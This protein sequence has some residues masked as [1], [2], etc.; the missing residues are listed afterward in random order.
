MAFYSILSSRALRSC[1]SSIALGAV[2]LSSGCDM[3]TNYT[4]IDR[5][6]DMERQ[7]FRDGLSPRDIDFETFADDAGGIPSLESYIAPIS[8]NLRPMPLV[9]LAVNQTVPLKNVLYELAEQ[10]D[11][12][13][14]LDP[15]IT[16]SIIFT[17]RNRPFDMVIERISEIA[18]LRYSFDDD[19]LRVQLD[20]PYTETYQLNYLAVVR[21]ATS[22]VSNSV[23]VVTGDGADAGSSFSITSEAESDFWQDLDENL[24]QILQSNVGN[25]SLRTDTDP[26]LTVVSA[27]PAAPVVAVQPVD[28]S[29]LGEGSPVPTPGQDQTAPPVVQP[30]TVTL[31]VGALPTSTA[32]SGSNDPNEVSFEPAFSLNKQAGLISVYANERIHNEVDKYLEKLEATM[33]AQVLVE[34]KVL[35]VTLSDEYSTGINWND[36]SLFS[37][38]ISTGFSAIVGGGGRAA[39]TPTDAANNFFVN[40]TSGDISAVVEAISRFGTVKALA[41]PRLTV[42]N[43]Q[44][45]A[46]NVAQNTVYFDV[47]VETSI[48]TNGNPLSTFDSEVRTVP[49][50][51]LINVTPTINMENRSITMQ[52]RPTVTRIINRVPD[53]AVEIEAARVGVNVSSDVPELNVQEIDSVLKMNSGEVV[54]LGGL[55][56]DQVNSSQE[57]VPVL[58]EIPILGALFRSQSDEITKTE[59]VIFLKATILDSGRDSIHQ[60]DRELYKTFANDRR[61]FKM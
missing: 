53:P 1:V 54:V 28:G 5:T 43:N 8:D 41:S 45:A 31:Q 38:N 12:D 57:G 10:A 49:E 58:N 14:E 22:S 39:L 20:T 11:Y 51:V 46:L 37:G 29:A 4:K 60:T 2:L 30:P 35:E 17:A 18:G 52:V 16:G 24:D 42:L 27:N 56:Q 36:V 33:M 47:T 15:R 3:A 6:S 34:V 55:L 26:T 40:Y 13:V 19:I 21:T 44:P 9:S 59:L 61:P 23:S 32:S 50:G 7:D 25:G 48:D